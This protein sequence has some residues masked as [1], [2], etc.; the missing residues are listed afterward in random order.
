MGAMRVKGNY[1]KNKP[2]TRAYQFPVLKPEKLLKSKDM[3]LLT[4]LEL[5]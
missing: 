3:H 5:D 2:R 1:S 4:I